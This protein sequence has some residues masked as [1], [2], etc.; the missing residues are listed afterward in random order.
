[1]QKPSQTPRQLKKVIGQL[2]YLERQYVRMKNQGRKED[3]R[4]KIQLGGL[5]KKA[6]L[7]TESTAVLYGMLLEAAESL[8]FENADNPRTRWQVKG[9]LAF[10]SEKE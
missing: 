4:R 7:E 2:S 9:D 8:Y 10:L 6:G 1:M 5:I 3:T